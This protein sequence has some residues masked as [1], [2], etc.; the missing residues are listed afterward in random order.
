MG[1]CRNHT[2]EVPLCSM[3][4]SGPISG[5]AS[6]TVLIVRAEVKERMQIPGQIFAFLI[7]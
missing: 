5:L 6:H 7:A 2:G 1:Q 3:G 4:Q